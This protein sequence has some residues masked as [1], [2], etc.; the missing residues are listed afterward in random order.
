MLRSWTGYPMVVLRI[1]AAVDDAGT[2]TEA[3]GEITE[4]VWES[5]PERYRNQ[6]EKGA[7]DLLREV[8]KWVLRVK[9]S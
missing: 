6:T 4:L 1:Q 5:S 2:A 9:L 7:K 8:C 3:A